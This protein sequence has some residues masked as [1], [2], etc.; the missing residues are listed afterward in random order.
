MMC[1]FK[2]NGLV[3][4]DACSAAFLSVER[5]CQCVIIRQ[6]DTRHRVGRDE[7]E[8]IYLHVA[9]SEFLLI[10]VLSEYSHNVNSRDGVRL[11]EERAPVVVNQ[12]MADV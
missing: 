11:D 7:C 8:F 1:Q 5:S 4:T 10:I 3:L 2:Y 9:G 6:G 12:Q